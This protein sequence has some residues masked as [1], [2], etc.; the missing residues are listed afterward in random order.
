MNKKWDLKKVKDV[1]EESGCT[2]LTEA[3]HNP[4]EKLDY[5]ATC[6]HQHQISFE[7]FLAGK[8]RVCKKCRYQ[9]IAREKTRTIEDAER[10]FRENGCELLSESYGGCTEK[11]EYIAQCGH[12]NQI[13]YSKFAAGSGRICKK[14]SKSVR[15][16]YDEVFETFLREGCF[17][18]EKE[19]QNCKQPLRFIAKCG[20]ESIITFDDFLN[21][22]RSK[23]CPDCQK[24]AHYTIEK[25]VKLFENEHC[26][27]LDTAYIPKKKIHYI[28]RCGHEHAIDLSKFL[29]GQGAECPKCSRPKG[30]QHFAYN[31]DLS[32][33]DRIRNRDLYEYIF[34][35]KAVFNRDNYIC[36]ACGYAN[37]GRLVAH[38]VESYGTC[39]EKRFLVENGITLC[40]KCHKEFH[41][42]YG[43]GRNTQKQFEEWMQQHGN[44]E[45]SPRIAQG[46]GTP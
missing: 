17:L 41:K 24:I 34:W 7:N 37:G 27:V 15:Y 36:T 21:S 43:Y 6:G 12:R 14:C 42:N 16:E 33:E 32:D 18:L 25:I 20:H 39:P 13:S 8:G 28:A 10:L 19:Y 46:R 9:K 45:V 5:I 23:Y 29:N 4:S 44:T 35:R 1:F 26:K 31:P 30:E 2:L 40:D 11:L 22:S 3:Y 38:H